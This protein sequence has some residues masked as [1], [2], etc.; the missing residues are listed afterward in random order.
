MVFQ[1][2]L[3]DYTGLPLHTWKPEQPGTVRGAECFTRVALSLLRSPDDVV[4]V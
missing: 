4:K 3:A 1:P 2:A